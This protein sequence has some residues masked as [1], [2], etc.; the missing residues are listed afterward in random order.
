MHAMSRLLLMRSKVSS[1]L[2]L[3]RDHG[4]FRQLNVVAICYLV[5]GPTLP[6]SEEGE[7]LV[8]GDLNEEDDNV[9]ED[10]EESAADSG[11]EDNEVEGRAEAEEE[12]SE[13]EGMEEQSLRGTRHSR[14]VVL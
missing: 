3:V 11:E 14:G 12:T 13:P 7:E 2:G 9:E 5:L 4:L 10:E 6:A 1:W 8:D